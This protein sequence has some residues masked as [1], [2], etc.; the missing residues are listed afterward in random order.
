M[1]RD[2]T[3]NDLIARRDREEVAAG[4]FARRRSAIFQAS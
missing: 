3:L 2:G 1:E 4:E